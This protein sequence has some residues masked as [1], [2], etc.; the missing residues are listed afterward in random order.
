MD[1]WKSIASLTGRRSKEVVSLQKEDEDDYMEFATEYLN[2]L[3]IAEAKH[4]AMARLVNTGQMT[5]FPA[6]GS[7]TRVARRLGAT[8]IELA[9]DFSRIEDA[10]NHPYLDFNAAEV[11]EF[12]QRF[13]KF[14]EGFEFCSIVSK[15]G[16]NGVYIFD[17]EDADPGTEWKTPN[18]DTVYHWILNQLFITSRLSLESFRNWSPNNPP[19]GIADCSSNA[20][21]PWPPPPSAE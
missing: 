3:S 14:G 8:T 21:D 2:S 19:S 7:L 11:Y 20:H 4:Q 1:I 12:D 9:S 5:C 16:E 17:Q 15:V 6:D 18:Y 10:D 13:I